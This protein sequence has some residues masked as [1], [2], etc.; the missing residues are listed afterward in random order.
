MCAK[1]EQV[2]HRNGKRVACVEADRKELADIKK[3]I[4]TKMSVIAVFPHACYRR[5]FSF[6]ALPSPAHG[7]RPFLVVGLL[8]FEAIQKMA[9]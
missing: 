7:E 1:S 5:C 6:Y 9:R 4:T 2:N 3:K 8:L